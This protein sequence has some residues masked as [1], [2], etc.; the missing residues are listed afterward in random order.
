[1]Y[2]PGML[3]ARPVRMPESS[4]RAR[5]TR[6][7]SFTIASARRR[8]RQ[9]CLAV[10]VCSGFGVAPPA[11]AEEAPARRAILLET[12]D[13]SDRTVRDLDKRLHDAVVATAPVQLVESPHKKLS[14][15]QTGAGCRDQSPAC[16]HALA[17]RA[18]VDVLIMPALERGSDDLVLTLRAF[19]AGDGK[20][21]EVAHWQDG[22]KPNAETLDSLPELVRGLFKLQP[23]NETVEIAPPPPAAGAE[24]ALAPASVATSD[25]PA[26]RLAPWILMGAGAVVLG[27]GAISGGLMLGSEHDYKTTTVRDRMDAQRAHDLLSRANTEGTVAEVCIV[28]GSAA[29]L[30]GGGWLLTDWWLGRQGDKG[31]STRLAPMLSPREVGFVLQHQGGP[32]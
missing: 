4:A 12:A 3:L 23:V 26:L 27:A 10:V 17:Q 18:G 28:L 20:L 19:D 31:A 5:L 11:F 24:S 14:S 25:T 6:F 8:V 16:L 9:G 2:A 30:A 15:L 21:S 13:H 22:K 7:L 29:L 32:F 1:M